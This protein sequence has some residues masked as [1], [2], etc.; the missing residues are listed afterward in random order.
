M[1]QTTIAR[2]LT[3]VIVLAIS[4][5]I[6]V[7]T[8]AS[9]IRDTVNYSKAKRAELAATAQ[10]FSSSVA[11]ALAAG[12]RMEALRSMRAIGKMPT[13]DYARVENAAG[14]PFAE[15]GL[16][17]VMSGRGSDGLSVIDL[18]RGISIEIR[19]P[20]IHS[21]REIGSFVLFAAPNDL[22]E[23]IRQSVLTAFVIALCA[24]A[25][26]VVV[27]WRMQRTIT[28]PIRNLTAAMETVR[29]SGDYEMTANV[30]S[31]DETGILVGAFNGMIS[32]IRDRDER[33]ARHRDRLEQDVADRTREY[34]VAKE[35]AEQAN[36]AKSTFL[37]TMSHEI[38][39]PMNGMLVMAE[40][41]ASSDLPP[42][43]NRYADV[44][45]RSGKGLLSIINDVLDL[46]KVEAG[47]MDIST[48]DVELPELIENVL[49]LFYERARSKGLD[50]AADIAPDVPGIIEADPT[51]LHQIIGNLVNNALKFTE[52]GSVTVKIRLSDVSGGEG[53][54]VDV[55]DT[56]IG[57]AADKVD[58]VFESFTQA[59]G[60]T[61]RNY[62]GTGLG[63]T[64]CRKLVEAMGGEIGVTSTP[65]VGSTF[66]FAIPLHRATTDNLAEMLA[67]DGFRRLVVIEGGSASGDIIAAAARDLGIDAEVIAARDLLRIAPRDRDAVVAPAAL[68]PSAQAHWNSHAS[69]I[70]FVALC[71]L[72]DTIDVGPAAQPD[73]VLE[74]P[75]VRPLAARFL[76]RLSNGEADMRPQPGDRA[77]DLAF[78]GARVLVVDDNEVNL[79]V[80][81]DALQRLSIRP[82]LVD[83]GLRAVELAAA[84]GY[85]LILMDCS[86]PDV[87]G[88]EAARRIRSNEL[89]TGAGR[90]PIVALTAHV[91]GGPADAW[92]EAGMD[93]IL[94]KPF[95]LSDLGTC[96]A[97]WLDPAAKPEKAPETEQPD[98]GEEAVADSGADAEAAPILDEQVL[99]NLAEMDADGTLVVRILRLYLSRLDDACRAI[100]TAINDGG[101]SDI[102]SAAHALKSMSFNAG[103]GEVAEIS[104]RIEA[105]HKGG[106]AVDGPSILSELSAAAE[107]VTGAMAQ[108]I[109]DL[110]GARETAAT[111][112]SAG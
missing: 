98:G 53:L 88:F 93:D 91:A 22:A 42:K 29:R 58:K 19:Q 106:D 94:S 83:G 60:S 3:V 23:R 92:R 80:A 25:L 47:K 26:G 72:G 17:V 76:N 16:G 49:T 102:A 86:M 69:A 20:V 51:R 43:Q 68:F 67:G 96:L 79:E 81:R 36:A 61:T 73:A 30:E 35:N 7:V 97:R 109:A 21:G 15:M 57:I 4:I 1:K 101:G 75:V 5:T 24:G 103:A 6:A 87:D 34:L 10:V 13:I 85:D 104:A 108:R 112:A 28:R 45:M 99:T 74:M 70:S 32:E 2:R 38:R 84:G 107:R 40:L 77:A 48:I 90:V 9:I 95:S 66:S 54:R 78:D 44:I 11:D 65:G 46:S 37:A 64:I 41:L 33:L 71:G 12:D 50:L 110:E 82:D 8:V 52:S 63:L 39:T 105:A 111:N 27:A 62:G 31:G 55:A 59:D 56:G 14:E 18:W 100:E 89:D